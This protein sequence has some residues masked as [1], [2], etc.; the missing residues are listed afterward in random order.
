[1]E[2]Q[3]IEMSIFH[4]VNKTLWFHWKGPL[5]GI[6]KCEFESYS[7]CLCGLKSGSKL[8]IFLSLKIIIGIIEN[9]N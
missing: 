9:G 2:K 4:I 6:K 1:M 7:C 3:F 5:M 8:R